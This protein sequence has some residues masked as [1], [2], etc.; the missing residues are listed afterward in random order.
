MVKST[1]GTI[2][3]DHSAKHTYT[4]WTGQ[5]SKGTVTW[6][7]LAYR[8]VNVA[9]PPLLP[10]YEYRSYWAVGRTGNGSVTVPWGN[11][12]GVATIRIKNVGILGWAG[13]FS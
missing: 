10:R 2:G 12:A 9:R 7:P 6:Q 13:S 4:V 5:F 3:W 11:V 1:C 8:R